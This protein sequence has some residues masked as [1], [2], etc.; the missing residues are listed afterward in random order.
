MST[1]LD[2]NIEVFRKI[3]SLPL[4][5][6]Q[7]ANYELM[8]LLQTLADI[9][10]LSFSSNSEVNG[11]IVPE[12]CRVEVAKISSG[13]ELLFDGTK[14]PLAVIANSRSFSGKVDKST[15]EKHVFYSRLEPESFAFHCTNN[16]RPWSSDWGFCVPWTEF[17][18]WEY[19]TFD[20][21]LRTVFEPSEMLVGVYELSGESED[22]V[23]FNAHTCHPTQFEDGFSGIAAILEVMEYLSG[24]KNRRFTY[25]AIFAP[26]HI[27]TVFYLHNLSVA[28]RSKIKAAVFTEMIG[29]NQPLAVQESFSGTHGIDRVARK[30]ACELEPGSRIGEFR[31]IVGND[32]TVWE[33][34]GY[35]IPCISIS[36][37]F[38]SPFY[39]SGYH[40]SA[41][42][43][44]HSN[45]ERRSAAIRYLQTVVSVFETDM[46]PKRKF[47]GLV[48]LS[49]PRYDLYVR[50]PDPT[51][52]TEIS[53]SQVRLGEAQDKILRYLNGELSV[54]EISEIVDL[55]FDT[56]LQ[57]LRRF[58]DKGLIGLEPAVGVRS[59]LNRQATVAQTM[60][61][62][63]PRN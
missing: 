1:W 55:P 34:P 62:Q 44:E 36:R 12:N 30:I 24:L 43:I 27:G 4:G 42:R 23:V 28:E 54:F 2:Q 22:T 17:S 9:K 21:D 56:I 8:S 45:F 31:S 38:E 60:K 51:V 25:R 49:N 57:Y 3:L 61:V 33:A 13:G 10:I 41:D 29:L 40:T 37:C 47:E 39:Y 48:A 58:E 11:W 59:L 50:R 53:E 32:E 15:L 52:P 18:K 35:E 19:E 20:I 63:Q 16:Y 46:I 14:H 5:V 26:E 7:S 6:A